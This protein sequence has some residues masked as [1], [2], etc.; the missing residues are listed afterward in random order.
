M[1]TRRGGNDNFSAYRRYFVST[2]LPQLNAGGSNAINNTGTASRSARLNYFGRV[3][4]NY[5]EK[6]LAEFVW[7]VDGSYIF[8][9]AGRYGFFPGVSVGWRLS[10]EN[11]WKDALGGVSDNVKLRAS[12]G[13]TGNDRIDPFQ[14]LSTYGFNATNFI[15]DVTNETR[16]LQ[17]TRIPNPNVTWEVAKQMNVGI[18]AGFLQDKLFVTFDYFDYDRSNILWTRSASVPTS[19]GLTLPRENIGKVRNRGFDFDIS[20]RN[21]IGDLR[22]TINLNGGY[23][24]NTITFWDES[25]GAPEYQRSTAVPSL[26]ILT[27][28]VMTSIT[29]LWVYSGTRQK[30]TSNLTG[31]EHARAM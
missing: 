22:Y 20:Y 9:E 7:R 14:Y 24:K 21:E 28:Q 10:E 8:P 6:Y 3:N 15:V 4:Y 18:D 23:S 29:R 11:F 31:R 13:T 12:Y 26:Q 19:T 5:K 2:A 25:P 17:E 16:A 1:E 30:L 27:I